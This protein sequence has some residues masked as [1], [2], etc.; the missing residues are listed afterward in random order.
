VER[1]WQQ[2]VSKSPVLISVGRGG[3]ISETSLIRALDQ[4]YISAAVLDV[5]ENESLPVDSV[6]WERSHVVI[7]PHVSGSTQA[8][9]VPPVFLNNYQHFLN[10]KDLFYEVDC[11]KVY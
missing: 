1:H 2:P 10:G 7:S 4:G 9:G 6:L 5:F 11:S 8:K 3:L